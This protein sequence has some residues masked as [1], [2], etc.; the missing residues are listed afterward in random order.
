MATENDDDD[1]AMM[2]EYKHFSAQ[3][4]AGMSDQTV[5]N[6]NYKFTHQAKFVLIINTENPR[7]GCKIILW[8]NLHVVASKVIWFCRRT[9]TGGI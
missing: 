7:L 8:A 9:R 4:T 6:V 5:E 1:E 2:I 3:I